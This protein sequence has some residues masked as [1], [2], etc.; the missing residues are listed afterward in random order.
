MV[1]LSHIR[2]N[3]P[4][5][6]SIAENVAPQLSVESDFEQSGGLNLDQLFV[7]ELAMRAFKC[8]SSRNDEA[9]F[10]RWDLRL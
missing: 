1:E 6:A 5:V 7:G 8:R 9:V 2:R 3:S 10:V 4:G